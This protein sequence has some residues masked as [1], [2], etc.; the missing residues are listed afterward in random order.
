MTTRDQR[1]GRLPEPLLE[2]LA[3]GEGSPQ[4]LEALRRRLEGEA[5]GLAR[6]EALRRADQAWRGR[7]EVEVEA[8]AVGLRVHLARVQAAQRRRSRGL[9]VGV[10]ALAAAALAALLI[11]SPGREPAQVWAPPDPALDGVRLKGGPLLF[12]HRK[13]GEESAPL[14]RGEVV[15]AGDLLQVSYSAASWRYGVIVSIDGRGMV[16][17]HGSPDGETALAAP[18]AQQQRVA[19]D[20]AYELDD[21]PGFEIF[22]MV[23]SM[24]PLELSA[25]MEAAREA[26]GDPEGL[27][28]RVE[29]D[30]EN[31]HDAL[32][33]PGR[34]GEVAQTHFL[35]RK[36]P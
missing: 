5:G 13:R 10:P 14:S 27:L 32:A 36:N 35:L 12:V 25:V 9:W 8:R 29:A 20:H 23:A 19:L 15:G 6:L 24:R 1:E 18:D 11:W 26:A 31:N 2:R 7:G 3:L 4:E 22:V 16:T 33:L 28:A 30:P 21:A 34:Q 17:L